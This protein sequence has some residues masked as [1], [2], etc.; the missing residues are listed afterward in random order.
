[1][2]YAIFVS[3]GNDG[4]GA[5]NAIQRIA[6]GYAFRQVQEPLIVT[7]EVG[8]EDLGR[9]EELGMAIAAGLEIGAL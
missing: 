6:N 9:C 8:D 7:G 4:S 2:P 1:M 3:A 5:V